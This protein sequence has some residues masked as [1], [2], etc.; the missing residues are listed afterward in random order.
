MR[1]NVSW[2]NSNARASIIPIINHKSSAA[3]AP[4]WVRLHSKY[5]TLQRRRSTLKFHHPSHVSWEIFI[6]YFFSL[7]LGVVL[8]HYLQMCTSI[9]VR[10]LNIWVSHSHNNEKALSLNK[11]KTTKK[12]TLAFTVMDYQWLPT[13]KV[14]TGKWIQL[15]ETI[16]SDVAFVRL[17]HRTWPNKPLRQLVS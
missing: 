3:P 6:G 17:S 8:A 14:T 5:T 15:W 1:G 2:W 11:K 9:L 12:E 10:K 7:F 13:S 16:S 4:S